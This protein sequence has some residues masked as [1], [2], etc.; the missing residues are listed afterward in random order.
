MVAPVGE[1]RK[2]IYRSFECTSRAESKFDFSTGKKRKRKK[3]DSEKR[4]GKDLENERDRERGE[5]T[6]CNNCQG[7]TTFR[8]SQ[9]YRV[10]NGSYTL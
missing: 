1:V 4:R 7:E 5:Q 8:F 2:G 6:N 10:V 3:R 9:V